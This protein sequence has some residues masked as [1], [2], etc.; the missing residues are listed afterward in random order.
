[1]SGIM[2]VWVGHWW[3]QGIKKP[4]ELNQRAKTQH[5]QMNNKKTR[6]EQ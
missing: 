5:D 4:A 1:M 3:S 6:I 2:T